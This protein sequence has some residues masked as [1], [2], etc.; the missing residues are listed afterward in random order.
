MEPAG[1]SRHNQPFARIT[2]Q[3]PLRRSARGAILFV[4]IRTTNES[5]LSL[6]KF[7]CKRSNQ[8]RTQA[9]KY[10]ALLHRC[11]SP[12]SLRLCGKALL[13]PFFGLLPP[14]RFLRS[15]L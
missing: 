6:R 11:V 8:F 3:Y 2:E 12:R 9:S 5:F 10:F 1:R 15:L 14:L 7:L 4:L 13:P